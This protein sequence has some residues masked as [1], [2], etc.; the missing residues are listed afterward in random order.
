[1]SEKKE[2]SKVLLSKIIENLESELS[3]LGE[4][5]VESFSV[6]MTLKPAE[7]GNK[8]PG[9]GDECVCGEV[10]YSVQC[11]DQGNLP[12][13]KT[14][15][16]PHTCGQVACDELNC[17]NHACGIDACRDVAPKNKGI[18]VKDLGNPD[19]QNKLKSKMNKE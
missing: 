6:T 8:R 19:V 12:G 4:Q 5:Y 14:L 13:C 11:T 3:G 15:C 2:K 1:M 7:V 10:C 17:P 16:N 18:N 9:G